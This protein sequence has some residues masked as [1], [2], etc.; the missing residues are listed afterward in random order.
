LQQAGKAKGEVAIVGID[1][2]PDGLAAIKR[3][4]L[5]ASVF[6]DPKAQ[7]TTALQS[8]IK[9]IKGE[10]VDAEVWVPFQLITPEQVA[11]FEQHY[12]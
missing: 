12:K 9:M 8:A 10:P 5:A 6:Q 7:A 11:V 3:G 2:L 1:G 4:M